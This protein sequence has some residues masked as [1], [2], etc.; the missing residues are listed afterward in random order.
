MYL[1]EPGA[2]L[3]SHEG[4]SVDAKVPYARLNLT[5]NTEFEAK[6]NHMVRGGGG[7]EQRGSRRNL[8]PARRG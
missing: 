3:E 6:I 7:P 8:P 5:T 1:L 2:P 4:R